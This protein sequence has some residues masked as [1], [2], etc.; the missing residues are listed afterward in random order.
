MQAMVRALEGPLAYRL[1]V[2]C[3]CDE[4]AEN[5]LHTLSL[6]FDISQTSR[7]GENCDSGNGEAVYIV[8]HWFAI[9]ELW[10][11]KLGWPIA[12]Q[13]ANRR[14]LTTARRPQFRGCRRDDV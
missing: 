9:P 3:E 7:V 10:P 5:S 13:I 4:R 2:Q 12:N 1:R 11:S 8:R 14:R 6:A